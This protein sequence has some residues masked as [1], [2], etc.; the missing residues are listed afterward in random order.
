MAKGQQQVDA[1]CFRPGRQVGGVPPV[2]GGAFKFFCY[3]FF[4][5][6]DCLVF[7]RKH[8]TRK[9]VEGMVRFRGALLGAEDQTDWG[10][11]P[12]FIQCSRA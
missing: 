7:G 6:Q 4:I 8:L 11:S 2:F 1:D 3:Q 9:I 12:G 5:R 10:V